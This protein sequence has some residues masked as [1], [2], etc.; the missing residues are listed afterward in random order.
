MRVDGGGEREGG[1]AFPLQVGWVP[2]SVNPVASHRDGQEMIQSKRTNRCTACSCEADEV[3]PLG[4]PRK[5]CRPSLL[6]RM[7][8]GH[9]LSGFGVDTVRVCPLVLVAQ[10]AGEA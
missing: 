4:A 6:S 5:M 3:C 7:I 2:P 9:L 1:D 8:Q 10:L